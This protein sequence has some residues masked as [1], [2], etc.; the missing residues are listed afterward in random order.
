[1]KFSERYGYKPVRNA[2][3]FESIDEE[4]RNGIWNLLLTHY[5]D[6]MEWEYMHGYSQSSKETIALNHLIQ[7]IWID[8][9]KLPV[10]KINSDWTKLKMYLR[11]YFF[12]GRWHYIY[13]FIEFISNNCPQTNRIS[14]K[15][16]ITACNHILEKEISAY[17]FVGKEITP[18]TNEQ[19]IQSIETAIDKGEQ[20]VSKH[21]QKSL[22]LLS[23]RSIPDYPNSIKESISAVERLTAHVTNNEKGTLGQLLKQLESHC[24][25]HPAL[26][27]A[28]KSLY[29]YTSDESG[30]RHAFTNDKT[31]DFE[32][33]KFM[34]VACSAFINYIEGKLKNNT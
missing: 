11:N 8:Y 14:N 13:Y 5:W 31:I 30:I 9:F 12:T 10:D 1:M 18:I 3:Q 21:L 29:G 20:L 19:E 25:P 27:D 32:D 6:K 33:A 24:E 7:E 4:L 16:F 26:I 34:L 23:D 28:F 15:E 17:R 2:I 22:E